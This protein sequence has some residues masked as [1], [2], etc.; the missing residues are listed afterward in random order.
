MSGPDDKLLEDFLAG[1]GEVARAYRASQKPAAPDALDAA[2]LQ[3]AREDLHKRPAAPRRWAWQRPLAAAAVLTLGFS[4]LLNLEQDEAARKAVY[5]MAPA[6]S[7]PTPAAA[8]AAPVAPVAAASAP[9]AAATRSKAE[10]ARKRKPVAEPAPAPPPPAVADM[11][12]APPP[13]TAPAP[14]PETLQKDSGAAADALAAPRIQRRESKAAMQSF[15]AEAQRAAP[16][17]EEWLQRIRALRDAQRVDEA[18]QQLREFR[19][20]HPD[21]AVPEDLQVLAD[22]PSGASETK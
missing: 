13:Q 18:R 1:K 10:S 21:Y 6:E 8:P 11:P 16:R 17:P 14:M 3:Q 15:A 12:A 22:P 2:V 7:A 5:E 9:A 4:L 20:A 19:E